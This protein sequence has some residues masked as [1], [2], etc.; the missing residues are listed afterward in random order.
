L[1]EYDPLRN[2]A[3]PAKAEDRV[4]LP[5]EA[6]SGIAEPI[7][8]VRS[9]GEF[10]AAILTSARVWQFSMQS[11]LSG[12]RERIAHVALDAQEGGLNLNMPPEIVG[13]LTKYGELAGKK[14]VNDFNFDEHRWRRLLVSFDCLD[15]TLVAL[16]QSYMSTYRDFLKDYPER[17]KSYEQTQQWLGEL[18]ACLD[19]L[20]TVIATQPAHLHTGGRIPRPR[21]RMRITPEP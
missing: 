13:R 11:A 17:A 5:M 19:A 4:F 3:D 15:D 7:V 20:D 12:Y 14:F 21:C 18:R 10:A 8:P 1:S 6:R 2:G 9:I 16:H